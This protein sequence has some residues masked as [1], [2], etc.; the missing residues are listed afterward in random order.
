MT[1]ARDR[2]LRVTRSR[3]CPVCGHPDW[4]LLAVDGGAAICARTES[5]KRC[6]AA[7]WLHRLRDDRRLFRL[8]RPVR[9]LRPIPAPSPT[10]NLAALAERWHK[11]AQPFGL[12]RL[13]GELGVSPSALDALRVGWSPQYSAWTFPMCDEAGRIVGV[14]LRLR[15]GRK[16]AVRGGHEG[17]FVPRGYFRDGVPALPDNGAPVLLPE[18]ASDTAAVLG[19]GFTA[20]G[21]PSCSGGLKLAAQLVRGRD[22]AIVADADKPGRLGAEALARLLV[23]LCPTVR[24]IAPPS[25]L[26]DVR[27]WVRSG[28]TRSDVLRAI[29]A[30]RTWPRFSAAAVA[31]VRGAKHD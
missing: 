18:G 8:P 9:S 11:A 5:G 15:D 6:G 22:V 24:I 4:C 31:A 29:E 3:P 27:E 10:P 16:L 12:V 21:R 28:A 7:G 23:V 17:L 20:I 14:R 26:K 19:L 30:A 1:T 25:G 13:A 2:W